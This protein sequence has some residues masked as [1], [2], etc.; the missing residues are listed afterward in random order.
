[1]ATQSAFWL[2][3][4]YS[5]I[6][7]YFQKSVNNRFD[8]Q[9]PFCIDKTHPRARWRRLYVCVCRPGCF[10]TDFF[11]PIFCRNFLVFENDFAMVAFLTWQTKTSH[12]FDAWE[13][14][15]FS[16]WSSLRFPLFRLR[17][18]LCAAPPLRARQRMS[19]RASVKAW[20]TGSYI[21]WFFPISCSSFQAQ[22][23]FASTS[24]RS[25]SKN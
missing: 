19:T 13:N 6:D 2:N 12:T 3:D 1:M 9:S 18:V 16:S 17:S 21:S 11:L 22:F 23:F 24:L 8:F 20:T 5:M 14:S 4:R 15:G 7:R 10:N 25:L